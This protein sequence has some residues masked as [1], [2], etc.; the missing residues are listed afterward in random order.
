MNVQAAITIDQADQVRHL[1]PGNLPIVGEPVWR[2][3]AIE[4][5]CPA[6]LPPKKRLQSVWNR[7]L[8]A[9][10]RPKGIWVPR[11]PSPL[12]VQL[13]N[14]IE[15]EYPVRPIQDLVK[16]IPYE[17]YEW[18]LRRDARS[19]HDDE[20]SAERQGCGVRG[21]GDR[22]RCPGPRTLGVVCPI[23]RTP[24]R[25]VRTRGCSLDE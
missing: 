14:V 3:P 24:L 4:D 5:E 8:P 12:A 1:V 23:P 9:P 10:S 25:R 13:T 19:H 17:N 15:G 20:A 16:L 2:V 18:S 22:A 7:V 11:A 6:E 21:E